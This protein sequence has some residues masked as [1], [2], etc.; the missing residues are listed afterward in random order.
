MIIYLNDTNNI[1]KKYNLNSYFFLIIPT[2][3]FIIE[4]KLFEDIIGIIKKE[5]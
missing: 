5:E 4:K 1:T 3:L 2:T